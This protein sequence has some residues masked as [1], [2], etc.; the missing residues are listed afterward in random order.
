MNY[1]KTTGSFPSCNKKTDDAWY[2][3]APAE[4]GIRGVVQLSHGMCE[5]VERY[6]PLADFLCGQGIA[7][8]GHDHPGHGRSAPTKEELGFMDEKDGAAL[9]VA[10]LKRMN[11]LVQEKFPGVP[12]FL[13]GH[14]MGSFVARAYLSRYAEGLAGAVICGT[15]GGN[16]GAKVGVTIANSL[17][18][19]KGDHYRSKRL[20]DIAFGTYNKKF[21]ENPPTAYEWLAKDRALVDRY[22]D[23]PWCNFTFT[24]A[25]FR[26]LFTLLQQ[27]SAPEW[28]KSVPKALPL[29]L[30]AG[31]MDP[32]G[33]YGKGVRKVAARLMEAGTRD[34]SLRLYPEDR[35]EIFNETDK[36]KVY[37]D[38]LGWLNAHLPA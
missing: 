12:L 7:F 37:A 20:N 13:L 19:Q 24:T 1:S 33:D 3:Y 17:I 15:S 26:D 21:G 6:E 23:D 22:N 29:Y 16:P 38:L 8:C 25:G 18:R 5:Y 28:A 10:D 27:I 36:Q 34:L 9:L 31:E 32:V 35:H 14:S 30:I 11:L 4:G 2:C